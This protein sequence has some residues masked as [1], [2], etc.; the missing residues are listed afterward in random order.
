MMREIP[1]LSGISPSPTLV[2]HIKPHAEYG[3][4]VKVR[5]PCII[6][7]LLIEWYQRKTVDK[8]HVCVFFPSCSEY[9]RIAYLRYG[10]LA[11]SFLTIERL[12]MC[13][14][15]TEWPLENRP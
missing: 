4:L 8:P 6:P 14:I 5:L 9:A 13:S 1:E 7:V 10:F 15:F 12:K 3:M 2:R 11:A